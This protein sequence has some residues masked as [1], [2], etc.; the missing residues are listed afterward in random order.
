MTGG[1]AGCRSMTG[2][3]RRCMAIIAGCVAT[4]WQYEGLL[5]LSIMSMEMRVAGSK[6]SVGRTVKG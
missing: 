2:G 5:I 4:T 3:L 6:M 1:I